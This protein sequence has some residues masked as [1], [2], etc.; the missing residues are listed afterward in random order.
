VSCPPEFVVR[1]GSPQTAAELVRPRSVGRRCGMNLWKAL[2][3]LGG[4]AARRELEALGVDPGWIT[5]A[6][7]YGRRLTRVRN[8]WYARTDEADSVLRAWR[9]GGRLTCVSAIAYHEGVPAPPVLHVEVPANSA[10]LHGPDRPGQPFSPDAAVVVHW[11]RH[12]G[13]GNCRTVT[14]E[15]A[16]AVAERC[17]TRGA[18]VPR[19]KAQ[20]QA[21]ARESASRI[22]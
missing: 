17:G 9:V 14:A 8:G 12:P 1:Q 11:T 13:P 15:H 2:D 5:V 10:R 7:Y 16:E 18:G 21:A 4:V 6:A 19:G 3:K 20:A 22:V